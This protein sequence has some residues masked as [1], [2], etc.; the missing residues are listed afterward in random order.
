MSKKNP[1][2]CKAAKPTLAAAW[3]RARAD[4]YCENWHASGYVVVGAKVVE[5]TQGGSKSVVGYYR[6]HVARYIV[7]KRRVARVA[8]IMAGTFAL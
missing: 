3:A 8:E 6:H 4:I 7:Y 1:W 5:T 2:I